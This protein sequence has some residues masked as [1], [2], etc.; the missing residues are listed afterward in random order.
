MFTNYF[1]IL[2]KKELK[3]LTRRFE[4]T[5]F[6]FEKSDKF[7]KFNLKRLEKQIL[8]YKQL[9]NVKNDSSV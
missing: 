1:E 4:Y 2:L 8:F 9:F 7:R 3:E 6:L 5:E